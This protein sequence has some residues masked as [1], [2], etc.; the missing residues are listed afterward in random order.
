MA[1]TPP[2]QLREV[3]GITEN[4]KDRI[5]NFLQGAVYCWC[6]NRKDEWFSLRDLMGGKNYYWEGTPLVVLYEKQE[7]AGV[8]N[9]SAIEQAGKEAGWLLKRVISDDL[10]RFETQEEELVRKYR[11]IPNAS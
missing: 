8:P 4:E 9:Q 10:R 11:W 2:S 6:K 1:L 7:R 5:R 3:Y